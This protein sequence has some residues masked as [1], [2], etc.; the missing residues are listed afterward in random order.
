VL[1]A[2][3]FG[4]SRSSQQIDGAGSRAPRAGRSR[5]WACH[6]PRLPFNRRRDEVRSI[7]RSTA[8]VRVAQA[9][10][11]AEMTFTQQLTAAG[12]VPSS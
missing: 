3:S 6:P 1:R 5:G 7:T 11:H 2:R 8:L 9:N 10:Q 12:Q 4:P